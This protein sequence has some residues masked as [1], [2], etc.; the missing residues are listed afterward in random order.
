MCPQNAK[1][2]L[3]L[4]F[5]WWHKNCSEQPERLLIP[6]LYISRSGALSIRYTIRPKAWYFLNRRR[7][8]CL[9]TIQDGCQIIQTQPHTFTWGYLIFTSVLPFSQGCST[10]ARP[11]R[12]HLLD[13]ILIWRLL[14]PLL[15]SEK[16]HFRSCFGLLPG[17]FRWVRSESF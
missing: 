3:I 13:R 2:C 5:I 8:V 4:C 1:L 15:F 7:G 10:K 11:Q 9:S 12:T 14:F 17:Y 16:L 6:V